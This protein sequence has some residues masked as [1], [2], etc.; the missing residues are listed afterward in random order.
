MGIHGWYILFSSTMY[1]NLYAK[2]WEIMKTINCVIE[3]KPVEY[4]TICG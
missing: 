2:W 3:N 1:V 4:Y